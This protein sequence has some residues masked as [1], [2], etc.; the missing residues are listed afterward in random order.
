MASFIDIGD[1]DDGKYINFNSGFIGGYRNSDNHKLMSTISRS[2]ENRT[3]HDDRFKMGNKVKF[4]L[5]EQGNN[6][7]YK[8]ISREYSFYQICTFSRDNKKHVVRKLYYDE[9][10]N[11]IR[12]NEEM[13]KKTILNKFLRRCPENKYTIYPTYDL[14]GVGMPQSNEIEL[15]MSQILN[16]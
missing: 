15:A 5:K 6:I 11:V 4:R 9:H 14:D 2:D 12:Y 10:G 16:N 1:D 7:N 3:K 13:I 8:P